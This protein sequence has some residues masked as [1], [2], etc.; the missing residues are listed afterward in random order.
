MGLASS[1]DFPDPL[2]LSPIRKV[3][4][5][6]AGILFIFN[7][8]FGSSLPSGAHDAI[9]DSFH[10]AHDDTKLVLLNS[11]YL[12]GFA[13]GPLI[14]GPLSEHVGRRPV[15][16]GTFSGYIIFTMACALSPNFPAL[17]VF[18]LLCGLNAASPNAV[19]GGL[20]ADILDNPQTRGIAMALFMVVTGFGPQ[21]APLVSG[22][23]STVSWRWTFWV[24]LAAAGVGYPFILFIPETYVPV[25]K[26]RHA[27]RLA[28]AGKQEQNGCNTI[29]SQGPGH[30]GDGILSIFMRPFVMIAKEPVLL[31]ASLF[32]GFTYAMF[33]LYF[34]AYP[35]IFQ[36][37]TPISGKNIG[38][39]QSLNFLADLYGLSP[40]V[41]GLAFLP[42]SVGALVAFSLFLLY[43]SYHSKAVKENKAWAMLEEYRRLPLAALGAP[44]LPIA[45]FWLGWS[46]KLSIHPVVPMMSGLFFGIG[47]I[48]I[49]MAMI[50][51][52]TDAYKQYSA[53]AQAAASTLRSCLAVCLPL[54]TNPMYGE[55]GINWAS[56]LLAFIAIL[57]AVI[58]FV[59]IKYGQWIR[60][61]SPFSQRVMKGELTERPAETVV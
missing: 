43:G 9:A 17:L 30:R 38:L 13:I 24:G 8:A 49:F 33:Y 44:L 4:I 10:L 52:L 12:V 3:H 26:K 54:A 14:F 7:S 18:R 40:G 47:Y 39:D 50:N 22:F 58:P 42:I 51:Y 6:L 59:F 2:T 31:F 61:R 11:L 16:I 57:L 20:Y 56:S 15:L 36:S 1:N 48:L 29:E 60:S 37:K 21:L 32:M 28:K 53:S 25:L 23:V 46:S 45:L 27:R 55:L 41:A 5:V 35:I 19:L 34:Q